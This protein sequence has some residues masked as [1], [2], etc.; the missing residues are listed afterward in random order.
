M[1]SMYIICLFQTLALAMPAVVAAAVQ[2]SSPLGAKGI[3]GM[4]DLHRA[5]L[6]ALVARRVMPLTEFNAV[7]S[8]LSAVC[9]S[10]LGLQSSSSPAPSSSSAVDVDSFVSRINTAIA[11]MH[12]EVRRIISPVDNVQYIGIVNHEGDE[13]AKLATKLSNAQI[14]FYKSV[15][16]TIACEEHG[17]GTISSTDALNFSASQI[18]NATQGAGAGAL[19]ATQAPS[20]T[21][22]AG[23]KTQGTNNLKAMT[24]KEKEATIAFLVTDGWLAEPNRGTIALGPRTFMEMRSYLLEVASDSTR[25]LWEDCL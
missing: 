3:A 13:N 12:I 14:A 10:S 6:Q 23:T 7:V 25:K 15:L 5:L 4:D 17:D 21:Q 2:N 1:S 9:V 18:F 22:V 19:G 8:E 24:M 16:D 11:M 20:N